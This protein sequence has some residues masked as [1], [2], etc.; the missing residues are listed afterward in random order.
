MRHELGACRCCLSPSIGPAAVSE[1]TQ[2][3]TGVDSGHPHAEFTFTLV[4]AASTAAAGR[5]RTLMTSIDETAAAWPAGVSARRDMAI[6][7]MGFAG[8]SRRS[9]LVALTLA[10]VTVHKSDGMHGRL[11]SSKPTRKRRA[12]RNSE[13]VSQGEP[14][15]DVQ[16]HRGWACL[17]RSRIRGQRG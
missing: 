17:G 11:R 12:Y 10:D 15:S 6:L 3:A 13:T 5:H 14:S 2:A 8:A 16:R 4:R 7:L 9:E 1:V